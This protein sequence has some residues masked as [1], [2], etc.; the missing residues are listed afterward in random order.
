MKEG[1]GLCYKIF[2]FNVS[3]TLNEE[4]MVCS[5]LM[6]TF[7]IIEAVGSDNNILRREFQ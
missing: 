3:R 5:N 4:E 6:L 1:A 2:Y 7:R